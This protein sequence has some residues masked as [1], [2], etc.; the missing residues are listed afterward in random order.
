MKRVL[1]FQRRLCF[2]ISGQKPTPGVAVVGTALLQQR[3]VIEGRSRQ[4]PSQAVASN[5]ASL[6]VPWISRERHSSEALSWWLGGICHV[7]SLSLSPAST[8]AHTD[9]H[10]CHHTA[11][12]P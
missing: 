3:L 10:T 2:Y 6:P 5:I 12:P 9:L 4:L 7:F 1:I 8:L 11:L